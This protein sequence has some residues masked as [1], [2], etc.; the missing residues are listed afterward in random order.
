M[1]MVVK[2]II[3]EFY[4]ALYKDADL[5]LEEV[6]SRNDGD[7]LPFSEKEVFDV[8]RLNYYLKA[9]KAPTAFK[10][11]VLMLLFKKGDKEDIGNYSPLSLLSIPLKVYTKLI[12]KRLEERMDTC[13]SSNQA[14]FRGDFCTSDNIL[15]LKLLLEKCY[16]YKINIFLVFLDFKKAFDLISRKHLFAALSYFGFEDKWIRIIMDLYKDSIISFKYLG[17]F[18]DIESN[19]GVKQ[20]DSSQSWYN[21]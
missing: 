5:P 11:A 3:D 17:Q 7:V 8:L 20:G 12:L 9:E 16:E 10:K 18:L 13:I 15:S 21:T 14:G 4:G 2:D 1:S 19:A 6:T